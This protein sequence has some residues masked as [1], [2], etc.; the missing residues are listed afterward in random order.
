MPILGML[1][2]EDIG[3]P[4]EIGGKT[5]LSGMSSDA[6]GILRGYGKKNYYLF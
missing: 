6:L 4:V 5:H 3:M 1:H 2:C